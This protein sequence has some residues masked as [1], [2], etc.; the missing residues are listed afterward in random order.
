VARQDI[1]LRGSAP[2]QSSA[3]PTPRVLIVLVLLAAGAGAHPHSSPP[4]L[5]IDI[6]IRPRAVESLVSIRADLAAPWLQG[7]ISPEDLLDEITKDEAQRAC[8]A[9]GTY[10][11]KHNPVSLDG[12]RA[13][14]ICKSIETPEDAEGRKMIEFLT[15]R[16]LYRCDGWPD[17]VSF[18]WEDFEGADFMDEQTIPGTIRA[19]PQVETLAFAPDEPKFTWAQPEVGLPERPGIGAVATGAFTEPVPWTAHGIIFFAAV[20]SLIGLRRAHATAAPTMLV[21]LLIGASAAALPWQP[22]EILPRINEWQAQKVFETLHGNI[23]RAF[24]AVTEDD[25]YDLLAISVE[26]DLVGPLYLEI[27]RGLEMRDQGGAIAAVGNIERRGSDIDVSHSGEFRV[28]WRW[29]VYAH[30]TH[31]GHTHARVNEYVANFVVR[32]DGPGWRIASYE[33]LESERIPLEDEK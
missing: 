33:V 8:A 26:P 20:F 18:V 21:L 11:S 28:R 2:I 30:I 19:G 3:V 5:Y 12:V 17:K 1:D 32:A 7:T 22:R 6:T 24:E 25:I 15:F 31:W 10:F 13:P 16:I 29:R 14:A 4:T 23:Y 27:L 9:I